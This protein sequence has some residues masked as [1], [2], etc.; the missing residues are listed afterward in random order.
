VRIK[1]KGRDITWTRNITAKNGG[2]P[3][4]AR[5]AKIEKARATSRGKKRF[6]FG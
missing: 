4:L 2:L 1:A 3:M 5:F 6:F